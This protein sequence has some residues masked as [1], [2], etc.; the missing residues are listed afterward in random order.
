MKVRRSRVGTSFEDYLREEGQF[1]ATDA[2]VTKRILA[3]QISKVMK[4]EKLSKTALAERVG[5]SRAQLDRLLDPTNSAVTVD[6]LIRVA[7]ALGKRLRIE[8]AA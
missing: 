8:L 1:D 5:T 4:R 7:T 6:S 3:W 2:V